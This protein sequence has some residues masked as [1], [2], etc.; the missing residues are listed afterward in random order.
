MSILFLL[1]VLRGGGRGGGDIMPDVAEE[2]DESAD[3]DLFR[4][5]G[6][7]GDFKL[8]VRERLSPSS[9]D[10]A[11]WFRARCAAPDRRVGGGGGAAL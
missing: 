5:G 3:I 8:D 11:C 7:G 1:D 4:D 2:G 9:D 10:E 6:G